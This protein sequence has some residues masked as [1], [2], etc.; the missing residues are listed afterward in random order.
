[1]IQAWQK[2]LLNNKP[3][4]NLTYRAG[5]HDVKLDAGQYQITVIGGGGGAALLNTG[6]YYGLAKGGVGGTLTAIVNIP[7]RQ[8]IT[9]NVGSGGTSTIN[10]GATAAGTAGNNTSI[11]GIDG[12][13]MIAGGGTAA[14]V[15]PGGY[16][17]VKVQGVQGTNTV[18]GVLEILA[19]NTNKITSIQRTR[20]PN[21]PNTN[22]GGGQANTNW[23]DNTS[24]G[25]GGDVAWN[26]AGTLTEQPGGDGLVNIRS[27]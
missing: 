21:N 16:T 20:T 26:Y 12:V 9:L 5:T 11:S 13:V 22:A 27:L 19:D 23:P 3:S 24:A 7:V 4:V 8:T 15:T 6:G 25:C 10:S 18:S 17:G 1:M 2:R 14:T